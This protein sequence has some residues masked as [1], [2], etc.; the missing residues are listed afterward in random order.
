M[1]TGAGFDL[2]EEWRSMALSSDFDIVDDETNRRMCVSK[3]KEK[4]GKNHKIK[5]YVGS[6]SL[7]AWGK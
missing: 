2:A 7:D 3:S 5:G 6:R 1:D 4:K